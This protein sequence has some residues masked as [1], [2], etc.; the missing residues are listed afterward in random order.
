[1]VEGERFIVGRSSQADVQIEDPGISR[2]HVQVEIAH[3]VVT[4]QDLGSKSGTYINDYRL[5][6]SK[7]IRYRQGDLIRL[8]TGGLYLS[9]D[10][11]A[12]TE[13]IVNDLEFGD[14]VVDLIKHS[15]VSEKL[16]GW[17]DEKLGGT[18]GEYGSVA[19]HNLVN[20][21]EEIA[22]KDRQAEYQAARI[23]SAADA[24]GAGVKK[25]AATEA[26]RIIAHAKNVIG[27]YD[28]R[29]RHQALKIV[30]EER[31]KGQ[32]EADEVRKEADQDR[33]RIEGVAKQT[34][35][36]AHARRDQILAEVQEQMD[37]ALS[38]VEKE[39]ER[40]MLEA[41]EEIE[42][43]K[44]RAHAEAQA[45][46]DELI[47]RTKRKLEEEKEQFLQGARDAYEEGK[48]KG[49]EI[50]EEAQREARQHEQE[51]REKLDHELGDLRREAEEERERLF[52]DTK[53]QVDQLEFEARERA[54]N[55]LKDHQDKVIELSS[56][57]ERLELRHKEL[58]QNY[59]EAQT[60]LSSFREKADEERQGA[61]QRLRDLQSEVEA[62]VRLAAS[63]EE[64]LLAEAKKEAQDIIDEARKE[65]EDHVARGQ[66]SANEIIRK[67][68]QS[69]QEKLKGAQEE[70]QA[71][72]SRGYDEQGM[73]IQ[74][75]TS[76]AEQIV[77]RAKA[78]SG[79]ATSEAQRRK[80]EIESQTSRLKSEQRE[81]QAAIKQFEVQRE[82]L[83]RRNKAAEAFTAEVETHHKQAQE[84]FEREKERLTEHLNHLQGQVASATTAL[85]EAQIQT[86]EEISKQGEIQLQMEQMER[87]K[88]SGQKELEEQLEALRH[89]IH[90]TE[91]E[92]RRLSDEV[93]QKRA[94]LERELRGRREEF[95]AEMDKH[96][97]KFREESEGRRQELSR[98]LAEERLLRMREIE[99]EAI[100]EE[101]RFFQNRAEKIKRIAGDIEL[102]LN[103]FLQQLGIADDPEASQKLSKELH[104]IVDNV[105][106]SGEEKQKENL[107]KIVDYDPDA[108][109]NLKAYWKKAA[110][111]TVLSAVIAVIIVIFRDQIPELGMR[112]VSSLEDGPSASEIFIEKTTTKQAN[113]RRFEPEMTP[114]FKQTYTD[115]I[116]YTEGY[117]NFEEDK[118]IRKRWIVSLNEFLVEKMGLSDNAVVELV[119][120]EVSLIKRLR[121]MRLD[122]DARYQLS[123]IG[124]MRGIETEFVSEMKDILGSEKAVARFFGFKKDFFEKSRLPASESQ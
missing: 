81:L 113:E 7:A 61:E 83:D 5:P 87:K 94:R 76:E 25:K 21:L 32:R 56:E 1:M 108:S 99:A 43:I 100:S 10:S 47:E 68:D 118:A 120:K 9:I 73:I 63:Q 33:E 80:E 122:I 86:D 67:A 35:E 62:K 46:R 59:Y 22:E 39:K 14:R 60:K 52:K 65:G 70:F 27:T 115:N 34:L 109:I 42:G 57:I 119:G 24:L 112:A 74:R 36:E 3:S 49:Q 121:D 28:E 106:G 104:A 4:L 12:A 29:A 88:T 31:A 53:T 30:E 107:K 37:Q 117:L 78:E 6:S 93:D 96:S 64:E 82:E 110:I 105:L 17:I 97:Q 98:E 8:G 103:P 41:R 13:L 79:E 44:A 20:I 114:E 54:E 51:T 102:N 40:T 111:G 95:D 69:A 23:L 38:Q 45:D 124:K 2:Q 16:K 72:L 123:A 48:Q 19:R 75:A 71:M 50:I 91:S 55:I 101:K 18:R 77:Q 11:L 58:E 92:G 89:E 66:E 26:E 90:Q 84:R 85:E 116:I 15:E